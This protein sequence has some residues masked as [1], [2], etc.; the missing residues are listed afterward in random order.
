MKLLM[1][2]AILLHSSKNLLQ[3]PAKSKPHSQSNKLTLLACII[4]GKNQEQQTFQQRASE[5]SNRVGIHQQPKDMTTKLGNGKCFVVKRLL[6][7]FEHV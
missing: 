6:I 5:S 1:D 7:P 4:P 2:I 3:N